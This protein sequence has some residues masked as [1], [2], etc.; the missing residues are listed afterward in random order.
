MLGGIL[1]DNIVSYQNR[2][3]LRCNGCHLCYDSYSVEGEFGNVEVYGKLGGG[4][5]T[6]PL[7]YL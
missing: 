2:K 3:S 7:K 4:N 6:Q 1:V 5:H